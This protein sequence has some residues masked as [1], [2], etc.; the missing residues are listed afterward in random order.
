[1][2]FT[3]AATKG[4]IALAD[5]YTLA[6]LDTA[7]NI[8]VSHDG[9]ATWSA[10]NHS[11]FPN[12]FTPA[13]VAHSAGMNSFALATTG[14]VWHLNAIVPAGSIAVTG[15]CGSACGS[16]NPQV[17]FTFNTSEVSEGSLINVALD[18]AGWTYAS[19]DPPETCTLAENAD[20][21]L[22][23]NVLAALVQ[24]DGFVKANDNKCATE[25]IDLYAL[26]ALSGLR[27]LN[28]DN[29]CE[30]AR[31]EVIVNQ[32]Y[33]VLNNYNNPPKGSG[34]WG[35]GAFFGLYHW[36][37]TQLQQWCIGTYTPILDALNPVGGTD[38]QYTTTGPA[39]TKMPGRYVN[40]DI[41]AEVDIATGTDFEPILFPAPVLRVYNTNFFS[42]QPNS[43]YTWNNTD[44][45]QRGPGGDPT[46]VCGG[47]KIL[48]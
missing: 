13:A 1:M 18:C 6:V 29:S 12:S 42:G 41:P 48:D 2:G 38:L 21:V 43:I 30:C 37:G 39:P 20:T 28:S 26:L 19:G 10:V 36:A 23:T 11:S 27:V 25:V 33:Y 45:R 35:I 47:Y 40:G 32:K 44:T 24:C 7:G 8:Q 4:S 46:Q 5:D 15:S 9:T 17:N 31:R 3:P 34:L 22:N 14:Q 16:G